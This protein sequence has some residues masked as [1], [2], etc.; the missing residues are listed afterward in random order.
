MIFI[1]GILVLPVS[2]YLGNNYAI[3]FSLFCLLFTSFIFRH[4]G[5]LLNMVRVIC[6]GCNNLEIRPRRVYEKVD[7]VI[8]EACTWCDDGL[9]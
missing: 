4:T 3:F 9:V 5:G 2:L 7:D 1:E 8:T 6:P